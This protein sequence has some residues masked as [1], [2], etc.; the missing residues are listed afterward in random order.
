[1]R[2]ENSRRRKL[3]VDIAK[4]AGDELLLLLHRLSLAQILSMCRMN[5]PA[6]GG[7]GVVVS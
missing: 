5:L 1:M 2:R 4:I 6:F 3:P 7:F